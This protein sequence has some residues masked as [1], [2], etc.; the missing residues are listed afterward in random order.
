MKLTFTQSLVRSLLLLV[1]IAG[2]VIP[3]A[4]PFVAYA[5]LDPA[6]RAE[7]ES[8]LKAL[9]AEIARQEGILSQQKNKSAT[10]TNEV[11]KLRAKI[12]TARAKI[13]YQNKQIQKLSGDITVKDKTVRTLEENIRQQQS[14]IAELVRGT[15]ELDDRN[16]IHM[17]L[18]RQDVSE[19]YIDVDSFGTLKESLKESVDDVR[20]V[21]S[22]T[23]EEKKLLESKKT[24]EEIAKQKL[25]NE[26]KNVELSKAEQDSLLNASKNKEKEYQKIIAE[27]QVRAA[28]IKAEL[29]ELVGVAKGG[30]PFGEAYEYAKFAGQKAGVDP[31]FLL[32]IATQ[33]TGIGKNVGTCNQPGKK[34]WREIMPGPA[35]KAS[36]KSWRDDQTIYLSIV[37]ALGLNEDTTPLSCPLPSGGWGGA[38]GPMQF[39]PTTWASM[40]NRTATAVGASTANPW[41]PRHAFTASALYLSD[42]GANGKT[43]TTEREAAC[44]YYSGRGCGAKGV[45]N[46]FY[47]NSVMKIK[48]D[49]QAKID[50]L[51]DN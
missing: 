28:K 2:V 13:A 26:R 3:P 22:Q 14:Y 7:L 36:G 12:D 4:V 33:E 39:I 49:I 37:R 34:S 51:E 32:A 30:I 5:Q 6:R 18:S 9:E 19:F 20:G 27:R 29:F 10:I 41:N 17:M 46:S 15:R 35:D 16:L 40:A 42:L 31:A 1:L 50:V 38:M 44:K 11:A 23:E 21:K 24:E 8:E 25:E 48:V 47:G 45:S 43:Y